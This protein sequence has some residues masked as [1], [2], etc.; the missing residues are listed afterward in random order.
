MSN[1]QSIPLAPPQPDLQVYGVQELGLFDTYT[2]DTY[3]TAF[4]IQ[5]AAW[6]PTRLTKT[7][8]DS[9]VDTSNPANIVAYEVVA[10][11]PNN[12][13]VIAPMSMP[14]TE[15]A[16][17]NLT[18]A[19]TYPPYLVAPTDA[20]RGGST[21]NPVYLSLQSHAMAFQ[22]QF[23][24]TMLI[25]EGATPVFPVLYPPDEPRRLWDIVMSGTAVNVGALLLA[26][27]ANGVGSPGAWDTTGGQPV[28]VPA[29]PAPTGSNDTRG[30]RG[31]CPSAVSLRTSSFRPG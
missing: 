7:W 11:G 30:H 12:S 10:S 3:Q 17:V 13:W 29:P 24:G 26:M 18:G 2:R 14:A 25:D 22:A 15:A 4:E 9:T 20:T 6:D 5:P 16:T 27:N 28:W 19:V 23:G 31:R 8:F 21:I 1:P